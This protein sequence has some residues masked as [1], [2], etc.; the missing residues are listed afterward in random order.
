MGFRTI[1]NFQSLISQSQLGSVVQIPDLW[2]LVSLSASKARCGCEIVFVTF[3]REAQEVPEEP[4]PCRN[5]C[6]SL[7]S[8]E[9]SQTRPQAC[10]PWQKIQ[11]FSAV[12]AFSFR[13]AAGGFYP[14]SSPQ[15]WM[16]RRISIPNLRENIG[17]KSF[18][19]TERWWWG[20]VSKNRDRVTQLGCWFV[21]TLKCAYLSHIK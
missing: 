18:Y 4:Q 17:T 9:S 20:G 6:L 13:K 21:W 10:L 15:C 1:S 19:P 2:V 3:A 12:K 16:L 11:N 5:F 14:Q 8:A 7:P